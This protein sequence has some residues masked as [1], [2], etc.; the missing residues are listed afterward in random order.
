MQNISLAQVRRDGVGTVFDDPSWIRRA[1]LIER[2]ADRYAAGI[3]S[4]GDRRV[5]EDL[6]RLAIYD[7]EILVRQVVAESLKRTA[8][9]PRDIVLAMARDTHE[10]ARPL[11]LCSPALSDDDLIA[12]A[13]NGSWLHRRAIADRAGLSG[14]VVRALGENAEMDRLAS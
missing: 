5:A 6:F 1:M 4:P 8:W 7:G 9:L 14:R 11:L 3:L 2:I 10:V 13:R 12:I